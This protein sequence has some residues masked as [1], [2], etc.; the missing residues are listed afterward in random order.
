MPGS[1]PTAMQLAVYHIL[2]I[3]V[4]ALAAIRGWKRGLSGQVPSLLGLAF[5]VVCAHVGAHWGEQAVAGWDLADPSDCR[6]SY[7]TGNVARPLVYAVVYWCVSWLTGVVGR[8]LRPF[9]VGLLNS[10]AGVAF[11]VLDWLIWVSVALNLLLGFSPGCG[12]ERCGDNGDGNIVSEVMLLSPSLLGCDDVEDLWHECRLRD[13][14][15]ISLS[16]VKNLG[17]FCFYESGG[18]SGRDIA[19][20]RKEIGI[21]EH[22]RYNDVKS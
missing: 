1:G 3:A 16:G 14:R 17:V 7:M 8:L 13:A 10:L 20:P 18:T 11:C 15:K 5:G 21:K 9:G 6:F 2:V 12:L 19:L 22:L 4:C